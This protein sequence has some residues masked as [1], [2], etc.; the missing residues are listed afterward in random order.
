MSEGGL[1][2][3]GDLSKPATTLIEKVSDAV[4]GIAKPWQIKRVARAEAEAQV[5]QAN[6]KVEIS[7]LERRALERLVREEG[8]R[9]ENIERITQKAIP[10]LEANATPEGMGSDWITFLFHKCRLVSNDKM[11][12][13]WA[14]VLAGEANNNGTFSKRSVELLSSFDP[15]D[16]NLF[17]NLCAF[18]CSFP[19]N[20]P[21]IFD[22]NA[23]GAHPESPGFHSTWITYSDLMHLDALGVIRFSPQEM[24]VIDKKNET[25]CVEYFGKSQKIKLQPK[26]KGCIIIG[27]V[28]FTGAGSELATLCKTDPR[29]DFFENALTTWRNDG[30]ILE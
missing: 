12:E 30:Y 27:C 22:E 8:K 10:L 29:W 16:A 17:A 4:G 5:I 21:V 13:L 3:L 23:K 9:Q 1:I 26:H 7:A 6:A 2:N 20:T 25:T 11:Q 15:D 28:V 19:E 18:V 24:L 14:G